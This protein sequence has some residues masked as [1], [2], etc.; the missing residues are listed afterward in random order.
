[1][2][3]VTIKQTGLIKTSYAVFL[4]ILSLI[5]TVLIASEEAEFLSQ[6]F[7]KF[8]IQKAWVFAGLNAIVPIALAGLWEPSK[9]KSF[10]FYKLPVFGLG[11]IVLASASFQT[12]NKYLDQIT[13]SQWT[14]KRIEEIESQIAQ[15]ERL[16]TRLD[17]QPTNTAVTIKVIQ[18]LQK[19]RL[20]IK[21]RP[22]AKK[23][24]AFFIVGLLTAVRVILWV[25]AIGMS[26]KA[27]EI[28]RLP[29]TSNADEFTKNTDLTALNLEITELKSINQNQMK[30]YE[31]RIHELLGQ[32][33]DQH[34]LIEELQSSP[35]DT[36]E[37][38]EVMKLLNQSRSDLKKK[39]D[40]LLKSETE[41]KEAEQMLKTE[42]VRS[43]RTINLERTVK[44]LIEKSQLS[45]SMMIRL[46]DGSKKE[47]S[48][49]YLSILKN[50]AASFIKALE[51]QGR[52]ETKKKQRKLA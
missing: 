36:P 8:A 27:M 22:T 28:L 52:I 3:K 9:V 45:G 43:K 37:F 18:G 7:D 24:E 6:V 33:D 34:A 32:L 21:E 25:L 10:V 39:E 23:L 17:N 19:E 44:A 41:L 16:L 14:E 2:M 1:M 29:E 20:N 5:I 49:P 26:R 48:G 47:I 30:D 50:Y 51:E 40:A 35:E 42:K 12:V 31:Q 15:N 11:L 4:L 13:T 38:K 46:E